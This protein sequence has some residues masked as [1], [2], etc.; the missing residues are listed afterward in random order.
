MPLSICHSLS[1]LLSY[2][3]VSV[4]DHCQGFSCIHTIA[5]NSVRVLICWR[6]DSPPTVQ[7]CWESRSR[8]DSTLEIDRRCPL[9]DYCHCLWP[10]WPFVFAKAHVD[11]SV[12]LCYDMEVGEYHMRVFYDTET[13]EKEQNSRHIQVASA[14]E[15]VPCIGSSDSNGS[16]HSLQVH[17]QVETKPL[18]NLRS[19]SS[20]HLNCQFRYSS[21]EI[22]H[23]S[24]LWGLWAG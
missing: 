20:I 13:S 19:G 10:N 6:T 14:P 17:I 7:V 5:W 12:P 22:F 23:Q 11:S 9:S 21:T 2:L 1:G 16:G 18:L 8:V 15:A 24:E 4:V 3:E